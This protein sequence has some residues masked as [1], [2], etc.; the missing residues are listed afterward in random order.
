MDAIASHYNYSQDEVHQ[1]KHWS[2]QVQEK[3]FVDQLPT[4]V[5]KRQQKQSN[6][7]FAFNEN[8]GLPRITLKYAYFCN[9]SN[10]H[11]FA[12]SMW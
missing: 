1:N 10:L 12:Y 5:W 3:L 11:A 8:S 4:H 2:L 9:R 7:A 6:F